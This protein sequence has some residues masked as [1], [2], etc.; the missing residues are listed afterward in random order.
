MWINKKEYKF[1]K[2]NAEKNIDAECKMLNEKYK[3]GQEAIKILEEYSNGLKMLR[4]S[5]GISDVSDI[6][7]Y[8]AYYKKQY[9]DKTTGFWMDTRYNHQSIFVIAINYSDAKLKIEKCL[10]KLE[11]DD[12]R[13]IL[14]SD[15]A[16]CI[17]FDG[18]YGFED[19]FCVT[20]IIEK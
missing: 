16:E 9:R 8:H 18:S 20:P 13:A 6:C 15:I 5:L 4:Q 12:Y 14:N 10:K 19:S 17:G 2:E 1:L 11:K 7:F 3:Q